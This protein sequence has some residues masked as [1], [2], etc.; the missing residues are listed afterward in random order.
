MSVEHIKEPRERL[1]A[2]LFNIGGLM[3]TVVNR[4]V[5]RQFDLSN[6]QYEVLRILADRSVPMSLTDLSRMLVVSNANVT[7]L[8]DRM[9]SQGLVKRKTNPADG[10]VR[11]IDLSAAGRSKFK[12]AHKVH[13][14]GI[15][16]FLQAFTDDDVRHLLKSLEILH[17]RAEAAAVGMYKLRC[18]PDSDELPKADNSA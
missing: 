13:L 3:E 18:N 1:V 8:I 2:L 17:M 9:E 6:A 10:R 7:G 12:Q 4:Q 5:F 16:E 11:L 15:A 14:D